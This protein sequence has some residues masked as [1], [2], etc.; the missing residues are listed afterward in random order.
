[1]L[2]GVAA[3]ARAASPAHRT[4]AAVPNPVAIVNVIERRVPSTDNVDDYV[5]CR[6]ATLIAKRRAMNKESRDYIMSYFRPNIDRLEGYKPGKQ[7]STTDFVKLN[8]NE[9]PYPPPQPVLDAV[10][11]VLDA[12]R[13]QAGERLRL[14]PDPMAHDVRAAAARVYGVEP[15]MVLVGNGSD[16]LLTMIMRSFVGPAEKVVYPYPTYVLYETLAGIQDGAPTPVD[17]HED[18]SLSDDIVVPDAKVTF[19]PNPNSPSGTMVAHERLDALASEI[20][21]VLV[22]DEAYVDFADFHCLDLVTRHDNVI[23][24]RS[25][26]K[27]FSLAGVRLGMGFACKDLIDGLIKV[28]DSYNV[29]RFSIAA[30][31]AALAHADVMRENAERIKCTRARLTDEL[32]R[33]G[34]FVYPSQSN[35]VLARTDSRDQAQHMQREL[36]ARK[37][38]V[39]YF[40]QPRLDDCLRITVG[41][42]EEIDALLSQLRELI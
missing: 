7:P 28:K 30:G 8:T 38:L 19:I 10:Q 6:E 16:D 1:M 29:N 17:F 23:V 14:Y 33:L 39:R 3:G 15:D 40:D 36:E 27:A 22:I 12:T 9:N 37:I 11:S 24:L 32:G 18:Y 21:G 26:S 42:D 31:A 35:F 13:S 34:F 25:F 41:M 20:D 5:G 4:G 2:A